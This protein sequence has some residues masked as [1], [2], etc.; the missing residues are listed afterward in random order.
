MNELRQA[1]LDALL[2]RAGDK[3]YS[4]IFEEGKIDDV[5]SAILQA[6]P[7]EKVKVNQFGLEAYNDRVEGFNDC[8]KE[9]K[10]ILNEARNTK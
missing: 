6:L 3:N 10:H 7:E 8:L 2:K 4:R 5:V 9:V 1:I